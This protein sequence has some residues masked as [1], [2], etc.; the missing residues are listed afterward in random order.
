MESLASSD[1][2]RAGECLMIALSTS[3][4]ERQVENDCCSLLIRLSLFSSDGSESDWLVWLKWSDCYDGKLCDVYSTVCRS[5]CACVVG[6]D[7]VLSWLL[8]CTE[9]RV[10][11]PCLFLWELVLI[12]VYAVFSTVNLCLS[13]RMEEENICTCPNYYISWQSGICCKADYVPQLYFMTLWY[14]S[15]RFIPTKDMSLRQ[16]KECRYFHHTLRWLTLYNRVS[17]RQLLSRWDRWLE[18]L[19]KIGVYHWDSMWNVDTSITPYGDSPLHNRVSLR[20]NTL[21]PAMT[22]VSL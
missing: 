22:R 21:V 10:V 7:V 2:R 6:R 3:T 15:A 9:L 12:F 1:W 13:T 8:S 20:R 5:K 16:Y 18:S 14:L 4:M 17:L 11:C 19:S